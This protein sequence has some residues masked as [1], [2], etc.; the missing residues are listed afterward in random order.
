[1]FHRLASWPALHRALATVTLLAGCGACAAMPPAV[2]GPVPALQARTASLTVRLAPYHLAFVR[3]LDWESATATLTNSNPALP[4]LTQTVTAIAAS[5]DRSATITLSPLQPATGYSLQLDL[6]RRDA[7]GV[8]RVVIS[9]TKSNFTLAAGG[10]S[11]SVSLAATAQGELAV[12]VADPVLPIPQIPANGGVVSRLS[13]LGASGFTDGAPTLARF[14]APAG[15]TVD[16]A[17]NV[18]V[19][20]EQNSVIRLVDALGNASLF[21]GTAKNNGYADGAGVG[22]LFR[23][24]DGIAL[25]SDGTL[26][27]ADTNNHC[28]RMVDPQG[29]VST[30][31]GLGGC[32]NNGNVDGTGTV[33]RFNAPAGIAVDAAGTTVYVADGNN[34]RIRKV[35]TATGTSSALAGSLTK[36]TGTTDATGAAARFNQPTGL[37]LDGSGNVYVADANNNSIRMITPAGVVTTLAGSTTGASGST[38]ATG[39]SA[40][41]SGPSG[42]ALDRTAANLYV[43]DTQNN[44]IR[45]IDLGTLAVTTVAGLGG[46]C[47][48]G[49]V[50]GTGTAARFRKPFG[51]AVDANGAVYVG[52]QGNN[53]IRKVE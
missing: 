15:L 36:A 9:G 5:A 28:L 17:G 40:L 29:N 7:A 33:A 43:A 1:M 31:A 47:N 35:D 14:N 8:S 25:A 30:L 27:V 4:T 18:Y 50:D 49:N 44:T 11:V 23:R 21:A 16:P 38:D 34:H 12:A 48:S 52:D 32:C 41:F 39:T 19:A 53:V 2:P 46:C 20:D 10:N 13:G 26:Y 3:E 37:A 22:V 51:V 24:A 45:R 6:S 42:V